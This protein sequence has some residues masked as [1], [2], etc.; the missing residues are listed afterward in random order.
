[1][2]SK[3]RDD[4]ADY[5]DLMASLFVLI[6]HH[7]LNKC[8]NS[9]TTIVERLNQISAHP[10][11]ELYPNQKLVIAKIHNLWRAKLFSYR[12]GSRLH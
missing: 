11:I 8:G 1:M 5:D 4:N 7:S 6:T 3:N 9:L 10:E 12:N 2:Q